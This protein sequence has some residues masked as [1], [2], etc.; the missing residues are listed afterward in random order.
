MKH[1]FLRENHNRQDKAKKPDYRPEMLARSRSGPVT[2]GTSAALARAGAR[3]R[4]LHEIRKQRFLY[5]GLNFKFGWNLETFARKNSIPP[6][7]DETIK[8][9]QNVQAAAERDVASFAE[10]IQTASIRLHGGF[11]HFDYKPPHAECEMFRK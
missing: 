1:Q 7:S 10:R 11:Y 4:L 6:E 8:A 3:E 9:M 5:A 2:T